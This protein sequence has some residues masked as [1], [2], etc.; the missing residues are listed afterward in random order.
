MLNDP[1]GAAR[2]G[3]PQRRA[4]HWPA[5]QQPVAAA[6][7]VLDP[8]E[9]GRPVGDRRLGLDQAG[10]LGDPLVG[11]VGDR[12]AIGQHGRTLVAHPGAGGYVDADQAV[13]GDLAR[14]QPQLAAQVAH[15]CLAARH[16]VGDVVGEQ[17]PEAARGLWA[18]Q[19]IETDR[20]AHPRQGNGQCLGHPKVQAGGDMVMNFLDVAQDLQQ[21]LLAPGMAGQDGLQIGDGRH[22]RP[23]YRTLVPVYYALRPSPLPGNTGQLAGG[24]EQPVMVVAVTRPVTVPDG[25]QV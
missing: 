2:Q 24:Y 14:L 16:A 12:S 17:Q 1:F 5:V 20:A 3:S 4:G 11:Q 15:Q 21:R 8:E 10:D 23:S 22:G 25:L 9:F 19:G 6:N 7:V 18:E 13:L